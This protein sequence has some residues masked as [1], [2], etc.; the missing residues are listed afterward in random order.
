MAH[1]TSYW[2]ITLYYPE[3]VLHIFFASAKIYILFDNEE[4][5]VYTHNM[6]EQ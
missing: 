6:Q 2:A 1:N 3:G 4:W 5:Y